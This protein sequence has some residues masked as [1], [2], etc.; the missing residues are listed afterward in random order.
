M[1]YIYGISCTSRNNKSIWQLMSTSCNYFHQPIQSKH[2][3]EGFTY[4]S[5]FLTTQFDHYC[6]LRRIFIFVCIENN[7]A[8]LKPAQYQ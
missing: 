7:F 1:H 5:T 8:L 6:V 4:F 3:V 2:L